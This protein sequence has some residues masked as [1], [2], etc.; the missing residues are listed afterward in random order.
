M[1][2]GV[3]L[4][5]ELGDRPPQAVRCGLRRGH[6]SGGVAGQQAGLGER[7]DREPLVEGEGGRLQGGGVVDDLVV[8]E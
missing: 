8:E 4:P 1:A 5:V 7:Q 6:Y 2:D 3:E